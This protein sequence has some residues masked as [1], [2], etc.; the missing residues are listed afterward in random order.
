MP[1]VVALE[2]LGRLVGADEAHTLS[3][4]AIALL[5]ALFSVGE[6]RF[7]RVAVVVRRLLVA[8][9]ACSAESTL[10]HKALPLV[11]PTVCGRASRFSNHP[12]LH[13]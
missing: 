1:D 7:R 3:G 9:L 6:G 11:M 10:S 4:I 2:R 5:P 12:I 8:A 13:P